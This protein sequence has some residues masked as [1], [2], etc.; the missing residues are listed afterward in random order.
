VVRD[1][2]KIIAYLIFLKR[3]N[4]RKYRIY[5]IAI[6]PE[7]RGLGIASKLL[8]YAESRAIKSNI[9]QIALEVS[10]KNTSA[11]SL[12]KKHGYR[13]L[14]FRPSYYSDGSAA[15]IMIKDF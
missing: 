2:N 11:I 1:K 15:I 10:E 13:E 3:K 4:S 7:A 8:I 14:G 9:H 6:A 5:S 12:Y